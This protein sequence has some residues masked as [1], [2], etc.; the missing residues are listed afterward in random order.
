MK[1]K[2]VISVR[3]NCDFSLN[4]EN[5]ELTPKVELIILTT[6]PKYEWQKKGNGLVKN[7]H[8][9][10]FR[11]Q[12][13]LDGINSLIGQLQIASDNISKFNQLSSGINT[14]VKNHIIKQTDSKK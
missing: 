4:Y 10:E 8:V 6:E 13:D 7:Q 12:T 2:T 14:I 11:C 9:D 3:S 5:S 1:N